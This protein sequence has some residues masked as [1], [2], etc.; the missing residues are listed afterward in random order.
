MNECDPSSR[1][2]P[3]WPSSP[4]GLR[5]NST[6]YNSRSPSSRKQSPPCQSLYETKPHERIRSR[7][8]KNNSTPWEHQVACISNSNTSHATPDRPAHENNQIPWTNL[9]DSATRRHP[10]IRRPKLSVQACGRAT[11]PEKVSPPTVSRRQDPV[12]LTDMR[13]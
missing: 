12:V 5:N 4:P 1:N 9:T 3:P 8:T 6:S 11:V 10:A 2:Q 13:R 7:I